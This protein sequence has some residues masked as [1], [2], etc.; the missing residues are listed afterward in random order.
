MK[1]ASLLVLFLLLLC[2]A[3]A[4][5]SQPDNHSRE[6][7][8]MQ[9]K[10]AYLK[11][12]AA[13]AHPDPKPT[14]LTE[15]EANAYFN[16]GGVKMP[17]GVSHLHLTAQPGVIDG[18]AQID[19]AEVMQG[20]NPNNPLYGM[21]TGIHDVHVV[22]DASGE[23]GIATIHAKSVDFDGVQMPQ[24]ALEWFVQHYLTPRY[25]NIGTTSTFK[26]PERIDSAVVGT[27]K[28]KLVQR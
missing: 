17:K 3:L 26:L 28:V 10:L 25:P 15:A 21:F 4:L 7:R 24:F 23:H 12:N 6:Y 11:E 1:R 5:E 20:R 8:A 14:E 2:G 16:E 13:R 19:F 27:G 18:R 9:E 22:A